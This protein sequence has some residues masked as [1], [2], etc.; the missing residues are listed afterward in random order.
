MKLIIAW[1]FIFLIQGCSFAQKYSFDT[2][3]ENFVKIYRAL[4]IPDLQLSFAENFRQIKSSA[5]I[6]Q[7]LE[8]FDQVD[9]E[10]PFY[11]TKQ[12]NAQQQL[13][14]SL[15]Q[16]ETRLNKERLVLEKRWV[17]EKSQGT[18]PD[19]L[20]NLPH[21]K[22]WYAYYL[23]RWTGADVS[24]DELY[25]TGLNE[26]QRVQKHIDDIRLQSG[27]SEDSFYHYLNDP[28]FFYNNQAQVQQSFENT[29]AVILKNISRLF[30]VINIPDVGIKKGIDENLVQTPGYYSNN[31]FYYNYF[32]KPYNKRQVDWLFIHEAIPGHH[33]QTSVAAQS[34]RSAVQLLF[35][36]PGFSEGWAA[37]TEE[38]G[39]ELGVY[40]TPYD[41]LGKWEWD[42]V[43][44]VRVLIDIGLNFYGWS[45]DKALA[46]WNKYIVNQDAIAM[47]EINRMKR[48]PAQVIT[49]KYGAEKIMSWKEK[50][51]Q[52]MGNAFNIKK[53]HDKILAHG[54][55]PFFLVERNIF[56]NTGD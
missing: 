26:V 32:D 43:R 22:E 52:A 18:L 14:F 7:Q 39:K 3:T 21:G 50:E 25:A 46:C 8:F 2:F 16:Y 12:K 4:E 42:I 37:Y 15:I 49:Y 38:L 10:L 23:K 53:F 6:Q 13:D 33:Y 27:L 29:K 17:D 20:Y 31:I 11:N 36:Y 24:P 19:N 1:A 41:E 56:T 9:K 5:N 40:K 51:M 34:N 47:R 35:W 28:S 44:S 48:W 55:L 54:S 30:T 45:D